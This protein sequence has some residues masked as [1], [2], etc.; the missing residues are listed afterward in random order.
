LILKQK[1]I[2]LLGEFSP[3]GKLLIKP[4]SHGVH[5]YEQL[6]GAIAKLET[7]VSGAKAISL[8]DV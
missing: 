8:C 1:Y 3:A 5:R 7:T 6:T 2:S 4:K